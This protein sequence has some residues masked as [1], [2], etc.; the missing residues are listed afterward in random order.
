MIC[1]DDRNC[2]SNL[3]DCISRI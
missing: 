2:S 1:V 3:K